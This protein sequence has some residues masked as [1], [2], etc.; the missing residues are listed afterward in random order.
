[1]RYFTVK[2]VCFVVLLFGAVC[3][4]VLWCV[5]CVHTAGGGDDM[6]A[7]LNVSDGYTALSPIKR[8]VA[9]VS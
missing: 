2:C 7:F 5:P 8:C 6:A 4:V 3:F 1:M 9:F